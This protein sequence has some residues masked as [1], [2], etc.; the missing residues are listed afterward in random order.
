MKSKAVL[1]CGVIF[2][3]IKSSQEYEVG[4]LLLS[5]YEDSIKPIYMISYYHLGNRISL[6]YNRILSPFAI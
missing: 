5:I 4:L 6:P 1:F 3:I 2:S